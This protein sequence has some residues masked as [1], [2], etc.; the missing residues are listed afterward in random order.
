LR[1]VRLRLRFR[2]GSLRGPAVMEIYDALKVVVELLRARKMMYRDSYKLSA[3][4]VGNEWVFSFVFLPE[5]PGL[6]V[7]VFVSDD[8]R[9]R[10]LPG[11]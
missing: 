9:T 11:I 3:A 7:T 8:G 5:T 6:D 4:R 1:V 10:V 2:L